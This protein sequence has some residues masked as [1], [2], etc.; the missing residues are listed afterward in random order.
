M[1]QA[2]ISQLQAKIY[3]HLVQRQRVSPQ[4]AA[5][6]AISESKEVIIP[7]AIRISKDDK[8]VA[9][10]AAIVLKMVNLTV[11][12]AGVP[13]VCA[14]A[15][16]SF[17]V[18]SDMVLVTN[19]L[20]SALIASAQA[21][22]RR[23]GLT[24]KTVGVISTSY[25]AQLRAV[26]AVDEIPEGGIFDTK[27]ALQQV[28]ELIRTAAEKDASDIHF[29]PGQSEM[30][31]VL[32]RIDGVL[33]A[34]KKID[35]NLYLSM[36]RGVLESRC[37]RTFETH[38]PLDGKFEIDLT[39]H[40]A[41]NIRVSTLPAARRSETTPK[42]VMRLL[43]NN[44]TLARLDQLQMSDENYDL[45]VKFGNYPSGM[46]VLTG[47]TGSGK[48]T[49]LAAQI[50]NMQNTDP[51]RNFSTVEDPVE[52]QH[53][54]MTHVEVTPNL[55]FA[56]A[57]RSLLRQDPDVILVG[58][59]R[60][61]ETAEL[62]FKASMTG[63]L[64][65]TTLHTNN[66]HES[67]GRLKKMHI[68]IEIIVTNTTAFLAQRL[69]RTLCT[70][71]KIEGRLADDPVRFER[72]GK[73]AVFAPHGGDTRIFKAN[74]AGC[75]HCGQLGGAGQK[76]RQGILEILELTPE[77]QLALV[78]GENPSMM[79]RR[80]IREGTF[81]DL[82]DDGLRLV[83]E[84]FTGFAQVEKALKPYEMD[85]VDSSIH[86]TANAPTLVQTPS[87]LSNNRSQSSALAAL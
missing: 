28:E 24:I 9:E 22:A 17:I 6:Q 50:L 79:R 47:P 52:M 61:E 53:Q 80:Q 18:Y 32:F 59:M 14:Q 65:L 45:L 49:T 29:V 66:A 8:A 41:I 33:R 71:C 30:V 83:A 44:T 56:M 74:P 2:K 15:S 40:K 55:T 77:V 75:K 26:N 64:V 39:A 43:S 25:L 51:N 54:G 81:K 62:G 68:D 58:E 37:E 84:G 42:L 78:S 19:P 31:D 73:N 13:V 86:Q 57:L 69:V 63:H 4:I 16:D 21:W 38:K 36:L 35:L 76:G 82:W 1:S 34:Q 3:E 7:D 11:A 67:I 70:H 20:D 46:I 72:Y 10:A 87:R 23:A 27:L 48:T 85:R 12:E 5:S 60:D